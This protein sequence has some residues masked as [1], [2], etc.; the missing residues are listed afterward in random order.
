M[1]SKSI[2]YLCQDI[3]ILIGYSYAE[4]VLEHYVEHGLWGYPDLYR[5]FLDNVKPVLATSRIRNERRRVKQRNTRERRVPEQLADSPLSSS[6]EENQEDSKSLPTQMSQNTP[7]HKNSQKPKGYTKISKPAG[8]PQIL[9]EDT[10]PVSI[11][12][13]GKRRVSKLVESGGNLM[14]TFPFN[15]KIRGDSNDVIY[16]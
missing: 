7:T 11:S 9:V 3:C 14:D 4:N 2:S 15:Y 1:D 12:M 5:Q 8:V 6:E 16:D 13:K 10:D